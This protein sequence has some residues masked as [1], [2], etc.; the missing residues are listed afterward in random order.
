MRIMFETELKYR[1]DGEEL[2][3]KILE[4]DNLL[5]ARFENTT[6]QSVATHTT[7]YDTA[8]GVL[9]RNGIALRM[10]R[11]DG[12][13]T[14]CCKYNEEVFY[15]S[16]VKMRVEHEVT[17]DEIP[18]SEGVPWQELACAEMLSSLL[19]EEN[20]VPVA[21]TEFSR[22]FLHIIWKYSRFEVAIDEGYLCQGELRLP[23][24]ELEVEIKEEG[25]YEDLIDLGTYL[26]ERY[27][28]Q[29]EPKS[30]LQRA[31]ELC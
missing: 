12:I 8:T 24:R 27:R 11:E 6:W 22:T 31:I 21:I 3:L 1:L 4:D 29:V 5:A 16:A 30:K 10:R 26:Q 23:F 28:L 20:L 25:S 9:R 19:A 15:D 13:C 18:Q 17:F 2:A 7:Y 14:M